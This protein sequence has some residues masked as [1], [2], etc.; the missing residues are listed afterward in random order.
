MGGD[1]LARAMRLLGEAAISFLA[2]SCITLGA[3]LAETEVVDRASREGDG[4]GLSLSGAAV[5]LISGVLIGG[6]EA[7]EVGMLFG[8]S[9]PLSS[10][11]LTGLL[12]IHKHRVSKPSYPDCRE[13]TRSRRV[14]HA[15]EEG[16]A[17]RCRAMGGI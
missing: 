4:S 6:E 15:A 12:C 14:S 9:F 2:Q 11:S 3:V 8:E 7:L 17:M 5:G 1:S 10:P 16:H 13:E